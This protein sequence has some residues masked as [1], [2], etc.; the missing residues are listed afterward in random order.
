MTIHFKGNGKMTVSRENDKHR[1]DVLVT[2]KGGLDTVT[3]NKYGKDHEGEWALNHQGNS[4]SIE[5]RK[6]LVGAI[7][8]ALD[9]IMGMPL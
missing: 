8:Q 4:V 1:I 6:F 3:V 5:Q 7:T 2:R 9:A